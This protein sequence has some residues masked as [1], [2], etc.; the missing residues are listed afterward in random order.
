MP[1]SVKIISNISLIKTKLPPLYEQLH[2]LKLNNIYELEVLKFAC[3]FNMK[4]LPR[5]FENYFQLVFEVHTYSTI[6]AAN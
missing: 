5:C 6:F 1:N 4:T 2:L 3:K